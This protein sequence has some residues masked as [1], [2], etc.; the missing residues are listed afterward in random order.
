M[1][2]R[3]SSVEAGAGARLELLGVEGPHE[4]TPVMATVS[5]AA[6]IGPRRARNGVEAVTSS[7]GEVDMRAP[8]WRWVG[9]SST[10]GEGHDVETG[11]P[12]LLLRTG[13]R[14][15]DR[16]GRA[17]GVRLEER[18]EGGD[19]AVQTEAVHGEGQSI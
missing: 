14:G 7:D 5:P 9:G 19:R 15:V 3:V 2:T 13:A 17:R 6:A 10:T 18:L 8:R 12:S 11:D 4:T 16:H 1:S